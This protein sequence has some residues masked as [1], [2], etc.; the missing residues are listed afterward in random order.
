MYKKGDIASEAKR[1]HNTQRVGE[2]TEC[3]RRAHR[4][5]GEQDRRVPARGTSAKGATHAAT[6]SIADSLEV[7]LLGSITVIYIHLHS[8]PTLRS[9][10][11]K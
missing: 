5:K 8:R 4:L 10:S 1:E 6:C 9:H 11:F 3:I 2:G 7:V